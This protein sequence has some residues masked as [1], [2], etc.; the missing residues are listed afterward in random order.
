MDLKIYGKSYSLT[1]GF[2]FFVISIAGHVVINRFYA[3]TRTLEGAQHLLTQLVAHSLV[4]N[5]FFLPHCLFIEYTPNLSIQRG[6]SDLLYSIQYYCVYRKEGTGIKSLNA[7]G[8]ASTRWT[9]QGVGVL[10]GKCLWLGQMRRVDWA[11]A[12]HRLSP[13]SNPFFEVNLLYDYGFRGRLCQ[14]DEQN[15]GN[16]QNLCKKKCGE[17]I[18]QLL[19][20]FQR[21]LMPMFQQETVY[22][23]GHCWSYSLICGCKLQL[24]AT[25]WSPAFLY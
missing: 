23:Y 12:Q 17:L 6:G 16:V 3:K 4:R 13:V 22:N 5:I 25:L 2:S 1:Y 20:I 11:P 7:G 9:K 14:L 24:V 18:L 8:L 10:G 19:S 21:L 15:K